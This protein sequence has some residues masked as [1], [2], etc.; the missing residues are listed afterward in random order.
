MFM[1][2]AGEY[3][4][5]L[6]RHAPDIVDA[7]SRAAG[8]TTVDLGFLRPDEESFC[9]CPSDSIDYAVMEKSQNICVVPLNTG[10]SD[11]GSWT[12]MYES[13]RMDDAGNAVIGDVIS[14]HTADCYIHSS[15]RLIATLGLK[16]SIIVET[17]DAVLVSTKAHLSKLK[18]VV[19]TLNEDGRDEAAIHTTVYR[20]W[21][22]YTTLFVGDRFKVKSITVNPGKSLSLQRHHH[23]SEHW[24]V[25][26]GT[27]KIRNGEEEI[28][29]TEDQSTY[30]PVGHVHRLENP[31][32][33]P[34]EIIEVQTGSYIG[35]DDIVRLEDH[36]GRST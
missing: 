26:R 12:A 1:F 7:C 35:E 16:D 19:E 23:R 28:L 33:I 10:W 36:Y 8:N 20:P 24:V 6:R 22:N 2:Q 13:T 17:P 25:V 4:A 30:I 21:G 14:Q 18:D 31:G 27:A 32:T 11:L 9:A 3:L 5:E 15:S 34:L 29:L